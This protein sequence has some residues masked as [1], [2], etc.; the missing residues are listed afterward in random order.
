MRPE[1]ASDEEEMKEPGGCCR[2]TRES[3]LLHQLEGV[4]EA[5]RGWRGCL[6]C[7]GSSLPPSAPPTASH[8]VPPGAIIWQHPPTPTSSRLLPHDKASRETTG[9]RPHIL[10]MCRS[11]DQMLTLTSQTIASIIWLTAP[12]YKVFTFQHQTSDIIHFILFFPS[13]CSPSSNQ[14][15][16]KSCN[17]LFTKLNGEI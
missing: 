16:L 12:N 10:R 11:S 2:S 3:L 4:M 15:D 5:G 13:S 6:L 7:K 8:M 9:K 14:I 1:H 17:H